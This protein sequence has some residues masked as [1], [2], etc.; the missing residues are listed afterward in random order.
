MRP[1]EWNFSRPF[2]YIH[3]RAI[4][5]CFSDHRT[6]IKKSFDNLEPGGYL[7]IQDV[8]FPLNFL[9]PQPGPDHPARQWIDNTVAATEVMG[10]KWY[11][12]FRFQR[13]RPFSPGIL[14]HLTKQRTGRPVS[15]C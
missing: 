13:L 10:R 6:F 1:E 4:V 8:N 11:V 12:K 3:A 15:H 14:Q 9:D 2:D 7:E 5:T